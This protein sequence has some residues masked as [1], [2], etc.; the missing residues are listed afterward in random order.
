[1]DHEYY[2]NYETLFNKFTMLNPTN[3]VD[4]RNIFLTNLNIIFYYSFSLNTCEY[5]IHHQLQ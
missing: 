5:L 3:P 4:A 1:M 2:Y